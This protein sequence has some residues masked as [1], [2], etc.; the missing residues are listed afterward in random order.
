MPGV[1]AVGRRGDRDRPGVRD[2]GHQRAEGD[3]HRDVGGLGELHQLDGEGAP[4]ER[5]L[6]A[7]DEHDVAAERG[8]RRDEHAGR[9]PADPSPAVLEQHPGPVDLEVVVVLGV[10]RRDDLGVPDLG[11]V[12]DDGTR[13]L[14]GVVPPLEGRDHDRVVQ[15]GQVFELD[16]RVLLSSWTP[17][18]GS[19]DSS[20]MSLPAAVLWD[21]DGTLVD[22]EP[23]WIAAEHAI[24]EEHGGTWSDELAHQLVGNDLLVSRASSATTR[25][26]PWAP[27]RIV[28][29]LLAR[30]VARSRARAVAAGCP[31]AARRRCGRRA[32]RARWS[33]CRGGR[34]RM[35]WSARCPRAP[36]PRSSPATRSRTASRTPSPTGPRRGCSACRPRT[37]WPSRTRRRGCARRWRPACRPSRCRTSS[38][39]PRSPGAC[40][41][42]RS[43]GLTPGRPRRGWRRL[44]LSR[45]RARPRLSRR[46]ERDRRGALGQRRGSAAPRRAEVAEVAPVAQPRGAG[47]PVAGLRGAHH[48]LPDGPDVALDG[49]QVALV[50]GVAEDLAV[51]EV[52]E[53]EQARDL[54]A[55]APQDERVELHLEQRLG[56]EQPRP[57]TG[58]SCSRRRASRR[59]A[60]RRGG[61]RSRAG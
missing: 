27:E 48:G 4:A 54:A 18:Y 24:V 28:D 46:V 47:P 39:C 52:D 2:V 9:A 36:S 33:R 38:P 59:R 29:E 14:A 25:A 60:R 8:V 7:L 32:C 31:R 3:D 37:A 12:L 30:V 34:W 41:S 53:L 45:R 49:E 1:L 26:S 56:L 50:G 5:R 17:A 43:P 6:D 55:D 51:A 23:Y 11:Q 16:H 13:G 22:T 15:L 35:P 42:T 61:R 21:M 20:P 44:G 58:R 10:E 57:A 19:L 40:T